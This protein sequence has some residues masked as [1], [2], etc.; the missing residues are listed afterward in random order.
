VIAALCAAPVVL[1]AQNPTYGMNTHYLDDALGSSMTDLGA[2]FVR[3][4]FDWYDIQPTPAQDYNWTRQ[5]EAVTVAQARQ[6]QILA[7]LSGTPAW[8][9]SG[10]NSV[11]DP[12]T[13]GQFARAAAVEFNGDITYWNIWNEPDAP[14]FLAVFDYYPDLVSAARAA[15]K[16]VNP[17]M[18]I[19]GPEISSDGV[20]NGDFRWFMTNY[21]SLVDIVSVH[22]YN[23]GSTTKW[24]DQFMDSLVYP[25]RQG[26][27]V[28]MTET[29]MNQCADQPAHYTGVLQ[30]FEPRRSWWTKI[31]FYDLYQ[32]NESCT[33]NDSIT[34]TQHNPRPAFYVYQNWIADHTPA[35]PPPPEPRPPGRY[36]RDPDSRCRWHENETGVDECSPIGRYKVDS[37]D[38]C[39]WDATDVGPDQCQP[40]VG[41]YKINGEGECYWDSSD[42][43]PNQC[44]PG[45]PVP[46]P[47]RFKWSGSYCYW[48]S[49]DN[50]PDQCYPDGPPPTT[51]P[52]VNLTAP[53]GGATFIAPATVTL[54]ATASDPDGSVGRVEFYSGSTQIGAVVAAP[55]TFSW[56]N[57]GIGSYTLTAR[58]FDNQGESTPSAPVTINVDPVDV[59]PTVS[60]TSPGGGAHYIA[61]A[62]IAFQA[63]AADS[64]GTVAHVDCLANG[65]VV[66]TDTTSPYACTWGNVGVGSYALTARA[67]DNLGVSTTSSPVN[68]TVAANTPPSVAMTSPPNGGSYYMPVILTVS[69]TASDSDGTV[70]SVDFYV[71]NGYIGTDT[72]A[73]YSLTWG[74]PTSGTYGFTAVA[75]DNL[76]ASRSAGASVYVAPPTGRYKYNGSGQCYWEPNDSGPNQCTPPP[77]PTGRYKLDGQGH[78]Y[79]DPYDSGPNQCT[80]LSQETPTPA[81]STVGQARRPPV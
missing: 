65:T 9:G 43:G 51:P 75:R 74:V 69:A 56:P 47:G 2:G 57:V 19:V 5:R 48:D 22:Y 33:D 66:G 29:G 76:G 39:Y 54:S 27:E 4:D 25:Y 36:R 28:W 8:M 59:P 38:S 40:S 31:F 78:C 46:G 26:K 37:G 45:D 17:T 61:P 52:V 62:T 73:P 23:N 55:Y 67:I 71:N 53:A 68:V 16:Q 77:P 58:A 72:T 32:P 11:P 41:R 10:H 14:G 81:E 1:T 15:I 79:W 63:A 21:G 80:P 7:S 44:G 35:P 6:L 60:L 30:R 34:D 20:V 24:V 64:D 49:E 12:Y 3:I 13:F 42:E 70:V 50:G 18:Q